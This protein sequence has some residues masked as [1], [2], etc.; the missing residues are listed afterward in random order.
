[1]KGLA[2]LQ[3]L[4]EPRRVAILELLRDGER[5]VGDL[6]G[7][8]GVSQPAVSKHLRVLKDAGLVEARVDA[9]RRL[10]RIRPEPLVD[11]DE[12]LAPY[13]RLW[14]THLDRLEDHLDQRRNR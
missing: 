12:W 7:R 6:V 11:L 8:L 1:M 3:V 2:A 13:R 9:Q 4:A 10:Y 5:P 14:T